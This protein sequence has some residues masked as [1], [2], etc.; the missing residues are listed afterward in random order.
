MDLV[1]QQG[2]KEA[3]KF[4][5]IVGG[6]P[7]MLDAHVLAYV[8]RMYDKRRFDLVPPALIRWYERLREGEL[9]KRA[10]PWGTTHPPGM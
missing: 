6:Q 1:G 9:W 5:Y 10:A 4:E 2:K 8:G 7:T 3:E